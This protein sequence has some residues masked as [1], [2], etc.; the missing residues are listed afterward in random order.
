MIGQFKLCEPTIS[1]PDPVIQPPA[2]CDAFNPLCNFQT[3]RPNAA[4][5]RFLELVKREWNTT[6]GNGNVDDLTI[7]RLQQPVSLFKGKYEVSI[8]DASGNELESVNMEVTEPAETDCNNIPNFIEFEDDSI[9]NDP[10]V[11]QGGGSYEIV[12]DGY[13]GNS[14]KIFDRTAEWMALRVSLTQFE[15]GSE[16]AISGVVKLLNPSEGSKSMVCIV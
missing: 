10:F 3:L 4:G 7:E 2:V 11:V 12:S 13:I 15:S 1:N 5:A 16:I 6:S 14:M 8:F 9:L